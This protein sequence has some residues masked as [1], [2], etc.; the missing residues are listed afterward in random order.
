MIRTPVNN[1]VVKF[2]VVQSKISVPTQL[3]KSVA[4]SIRHCYC[5]SKETTHASEVLLN[6]RQARG[7]S[8]RV[9]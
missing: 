9:V 2:I 7:R 5:H 8:Y 1:L 6:D 4:V 3:I